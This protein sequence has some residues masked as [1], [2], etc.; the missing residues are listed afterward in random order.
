MPGSLRPPTLSA[1][2]CNYNHGH[3]VGRAIAAILGQS[4]P[5]DEFVIVDDG[6]TDDSVAV[7]EASVRD[8]A[9]VRFIR[10]PRNLGLNAA[11]GTALGS[12]TGDFLYMAASDDYVRPG[13]FAQAMT[14]AAEHPETGVVFGRQMR[15]WP[16]GVEELQDSIPAWKEPTF[17]PPRRYLEE[18]L[19]RAPGLHSLTAATIY[20][21]ACL[22]ELGG[23]PPEL[24]YW[25]DTFTAR[26][27]ALKYGA[28]FIPWPCA[29]FSFDPDG[30]CGRQIRDLDRALA[31]LPHIVARMR[32]PELA[33]RFPSD[34]VEEWEREGRRDAIA[35]HC[36][37]KYIVPARENRRRA[38]ARTGLAARAMASVRTL[39]R[40]FRAVCEHRLALRSLLAQRGPA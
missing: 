22:D 9:H 8:H 23:M 21:R 36:W 19:R 17:A 11:I 1:T 20:R 15:A 27:I 29:V 25:V 37:L 26:A 30:F 35:F 16:S 13:F 10:H 32:S 34:Y 4:R 24:G 14:M 33:D 2:L 12:V 39:P 5:P 40:L 28:C 7:I 3:V 31:P 38:L 6:S 18:Y